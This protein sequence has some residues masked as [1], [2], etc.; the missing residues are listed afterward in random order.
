MPPKKS[1]DLARGVRVRGSAQVTIRFMRPTDDQARLSELHEL[2]DGEVPEPGALRDLFTTGA[3][4][5]NFHST[6]PVGFRRFLDTPG[7]GVLQAHLGASGALVAED[8]DGGLV[9]LAL[10]SPPSELLTLTVTGSHDE[11]RL[12]A[13]LI[14]RIARLNAL[15][16]AT[17]A[18]GRGIGASLVKQARELYTAGGFTIFYGD[19]K[20]DDADLERFYTARGF[21]V[22]GPNDALRMGLLIGDPYAI[23]PPEGERT[24]ARSLRPSY[25]LP[26]RAKDARYILGG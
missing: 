22:F 4:L 24:F 23:Y 15:A 11:Q 20:A 6:G 19:C 13:T 10:L 18:Q 17:E 3:A 26:L 5:Q 14:P 1:P 12:A 7:L 2:I 9:G 16:V 8:A 21:E 25:T